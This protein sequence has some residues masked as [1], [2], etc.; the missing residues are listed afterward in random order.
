M[1]GPYS[2]HD[3]KVDIPIGEEPKLPLPV[4]GRWSSKSQEVKLIDLISGDDHKED[5][6]GTTSWYTWLHKFQSSCAEL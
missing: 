6:V 3:V 2:G 1:L 4:W 5:S